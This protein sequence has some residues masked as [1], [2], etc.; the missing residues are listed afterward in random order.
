MNA[1]KEILQIKGKQDSLI[2]VNAYE[3]DILDIMKRLSV[4]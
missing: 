4:V 3:D 1:E 2:L